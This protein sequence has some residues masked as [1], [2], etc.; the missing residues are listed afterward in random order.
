MKYFLL[1]FLIHCIAHDTWKKTRVTQNCLIE[2]NGK[3][4]DGACLIKVVVWKPYS[5]YAKKQ[6]IGEN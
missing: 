2:K 4:L 1:F 3:W 6:K 5:Q